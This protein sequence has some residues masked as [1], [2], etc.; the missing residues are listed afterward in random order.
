MI[1]VAPGRKEIRVG[2]EKMPEAWDQRF[3]PNRT[4]SGHPITYHRLASPRVALPRAGVRISPKTG[5][6]AGRYPCGSSISVATEPATG[7]LGCLVRIDGVL[8]GLT[9]NHVSGLCH[10]TKLDMP[11]TGPG[12]MDVQPGN[13]DPSVIGHHVTCA[14]WRS[15][16]KSNTQIA[17]N[18]DIAVFRIRSD[19][20]VSSYQ[21]SSYDTPIAVAKTSQVM[22]SENV[23]VWKVG[24]TTGHTNGEL[25][26]HVAG[27]VQVG[28]KE[29]LFT[30]IV[31]FDD[32]LV[33]RSG[34]EKFATGGDSG[35][36]VVWRKDGQ[37][38]AV[39]ILFCTSP[40]DDKAYLMPMEA[41]LGHFGATLVGG[42][43]VQASSN[44]SGT[45]PGGAAQP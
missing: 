8:H 29:K 1:V 2:L 22:A 7:T 15:G 44:G 39:G 37:V 17:G 35:S 33:V 19:D 34:D 26:G 31:H 28:F 24:R 10:H 38:E 4:L 9:A 30:S 43:N 13:L 40:N 41:V 36:L 25:F 3:L 42:H 16:T 45:A 32:L 6:H 21:G 12:S 27:G 14:P 11:I 20:E 23:K 5:L 18:L